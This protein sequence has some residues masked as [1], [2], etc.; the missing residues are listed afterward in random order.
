MGSRLGPNTALLGGTSLGKEVR[1]GWR[2]EGVANIKIVWMMMKSVCYWSMFTVLKVSHGGNLCKFMLL[3][4]KG[5][6]N[7]AYLNNLIFHFLKKLGFCLLY[8]RREL[9]FKRSIHSPFIPISESILSPV[10]W[11]TLQM[12]LFWM[13]FLQIVTRNTFKFFNQFAPYIRT[14]KPS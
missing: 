2:Q 9:A 7:W 5:G 4:R 10:V 8:F 12:K 1:E 3:N 11:S 13:V 14:H 6:C